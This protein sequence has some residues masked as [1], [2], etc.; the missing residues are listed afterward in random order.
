[1]EQRGKITFYV[2]IVSPFAYIAFCVLKV[3]NS[4]FFS[5][6]TFCLGA[7]NIY[8]GEKEKE[9]CELGIVESA[10]STN[11]YPIYNKNRILRFSRKLRSSMCRLY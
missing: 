4:I 7:G 11:C 9:G 6:S 1:M 10:D 3:R 8:Q 5:L 2:D